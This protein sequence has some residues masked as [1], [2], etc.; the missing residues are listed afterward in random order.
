MGNFQRSQKIFRKQ[1]G[2]LKQG[3]K[4]IIASGGM[5]AHE[6]N[7]CVLWVRTLSSRT[8]LCNTTASALPRG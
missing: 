7:H 5:D 4:C 8:M 1:G 6:D 3:G 2:N